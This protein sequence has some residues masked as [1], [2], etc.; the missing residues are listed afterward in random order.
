MY[1]KEV[2]FITDHIKVNVEILKEIV[3]SYHCHNSVELIYVINGMVEI[4]KV[5][6]KYILEK[7]D[8]YITNSGDIHKLQSKGEENIILLAHIDQELIKKLHGGL[9][10]DMFRCRYIK[11][12]SDTDYLCNTKYLEDKHQAVE[13]SK[14]YILRIYRINNLYKKAIQEKAKVESIENYKISHDYYHKSLVDLLIKEFGII[15]CFGK[16]ANLD[17]E[18]SK[19]NY[20]F[21]R[22]I[23]ENYNK[24]IRLDEVAKELNFSKYYISRLLN[25]KRFGGL[26]TYVNTFRSYKG[27]DMLFM[28]DKS[29][30]QISQ[31][32]G[33]SASGAFIKS[34][35]ETFGNTPT[36]YR[37]L[38]KVS[39]EENINVE[40]EEGFLEELLKENIENYLE[41]NKNL[42]ASNRFDIKINL[43][44][45]VKKNKNMPEIIFTINSNKP[46]YD[47]CRLKDRD[48]LYNMNLDN[49]T[50]VSN[51][52]E[53]NYD[54][55]YR[56]EKLLKSI[57]GNKNLE[58]AVSVKD[59][60]S[61]SDIETSLYYYYSF[62]NSLKN[63]IV[64]YNKDYLVTTDEE[65]SYGIFVLIRKNN[66]KNF[67]A[68]VNIKIELSKGCYKIAVH[69]LCINTLNEI[70]PDS[71]RER[72]IIR[73]VTM[74]Q[75]SFN[76]INDKEFT[77]SGFEGE[78]Y[79]IE[80]NS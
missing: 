53:E 54:I 22:Y 58:E 35:K 46:V 45:R 19:K 7:G 67:K 33:F 21:M 47:C 13:K 74:P 63:T 8:F 30:D 40:L 69:K 41:F 68:K 42:Q 80:V 17:E 11:N 72:E 43:I 6:H 36:K 44:D 10:E 5:N 16:V 79:L 14:D 56:Y 66:N 77:L 1:K 39:K 59:L 49:C 50:I 62:L 76:I 3:N 48:H 20:K 27:R 31:H 38:S 55:E 57:R 29:V 34:F 26:N 4:D 23:S 28:T 73:R 75:C 78:Q 70:P 37:K 15:E 71:D 2:K 9:H 32:V 64:E 65:G 51:S 60:I 12:I 25:E 18:M 52:S 61:D 24:K